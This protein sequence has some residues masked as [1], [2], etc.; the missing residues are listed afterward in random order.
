MPKAYSGF[1]KRLSKAAR[2]SFGDRGAGAGALL[3]LW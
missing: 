1:L 3:E 2:A